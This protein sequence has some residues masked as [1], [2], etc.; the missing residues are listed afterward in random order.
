ME[1]LA[2]W[3]EGILKT[4]DVRVSGVRRMLEE[5]ATLE[6]LFDSVAGHLLNAPNMMD[7]VSAEV[8]RCVVNVQGYRKAKY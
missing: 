3:D 6:M 8:R 1:A 5:T 4:A 7:R 2:R